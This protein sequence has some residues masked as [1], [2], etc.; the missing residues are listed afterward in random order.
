[1]G[2]TGMKSAGFHLYIA[3]GVAAMVLAA[4]VVN[5][6]VGA[7]RSGSVAVV[8]L[9][10][11]NTPIKD[12]I[13]ALFQGTG[14]K[15]YIEPGVA[16]RVV[17]LKIKGVTLDEGLAALADAG[18]FTYRIIE[19]SYIIGPA[20]VA[21][22]QPEA[23]AIVAARP[24]PPP[25]AQSGSGPAV[26]APAKPQEMPERLPPIQQHIEGG[27]S[28]VTIVQPGSAGY[29]GYGGYGPWGGYG[30][31]QFGNVGIIGG[32]PGISVI[33]GSPYV[34]GH[35][36]PGPPPPG[37]FGPDLTRFLNTQWAVRSRFGVS[38]PYYG[39]GF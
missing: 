24:G 34:V 39:P 37:M 9:E 18:G 27:S 13:G 35:M 30:S 7:A 15:Y 19:G 31:Y 36:P 25:V 33:G 11:N 38:W 23:R 8:N 26:A 12:A 16:G 10:L 2:G 5:A 4:L 3:V 20:A 21:Y 17:E 28:N 1:M 6:D 32:W 22:Q 14:L 29:G